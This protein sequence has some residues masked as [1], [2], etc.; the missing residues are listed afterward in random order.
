MV[1][2]DKCMGVSQLLGR[3]P[4]LPPK[5][6]AY[7]LKFHKRA[8]LIAKHKSSEKADSHHVAMYP[9]ACSPH[10]DRVNMIFS[11]WAHNFTQFPKDD[12]N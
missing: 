10:F 1:K 3:V 12:C 5:V 4:R 9:Y 7:V 8:Y 2:T 6:Y 11:H